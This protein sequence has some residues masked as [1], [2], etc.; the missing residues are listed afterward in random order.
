MTA[1]PNAAVLRAREKLESGDPAGAF[2]IL[3]EAIRRDPKN[4]QLHINIGNILWHMG[5]TAA[6]TV[7]YVRATRIDSGKIAWWIKL[8]T[9]LRETGR[10]NDAE[11][12]LNHALS[13]SPDNPGACFA[14]AMLHRDA[15]R[16]EQAIE[17]FKQIWDAKGESD[18]AKPVL[19]NESRWWTAIALLQQGRY[20]EA[21]PFYE[22][23]LKLKRVPQPKVRGP[24]W[25]G[26]PLEGK[27]ILLAYEQRFGD[28]IHFIRFAPELKKRG[29]TVIAEA[30]VALSSLFELADGVDKVKPV[31]GD[32]VPY[33]F[34][35]PLTSIPA[36]LNIG[37][38][39]IPNETPYIHLPKSSQ[40]DLPGD[41][42]KLRVGRVWAGKPNP[43][44]SI[45]LPF[46]APVFEHPDID[47]YSFQTGERR[48][49]L[50]NHRLGWLVYDLS[51]SFNDFL[52]SARLLQEMDLVITI[53][54]APVHLCGALGIPTW[55]LLRHFS[56]WRWGLDSDSTP[57]YPSV[58][59][60]RQAQPDSWEGISTQLRHAL[61]Q[62]ITKK[63]ASRG[64]TPLSTTPEVESC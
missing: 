63:Y 3:R 24:Q 52:G 58:R 7:S 10:L 13:I 45:P 25:S 32:D 37:I 17:F 5:H 22:S 35:L 44:R 6:A 47:C 12:A 46:L 11:D 26:E 1:K 34:C 18:K 23:R 9:A 43:D 57:W 2:R 8:G 53:D 36:V 16:P 20:T 28:A 39:D 50:L 60:F 51:R 19:I 59:L 42:E 61:D 64:E 4:G 56:D 33:D 30:P 27:R 49:D 21:W 62:W 31:K 29:A 15:N 14:M 48:K 40:V 41:P 54:S 38:S 55:L